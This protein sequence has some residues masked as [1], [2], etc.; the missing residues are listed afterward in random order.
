MNN[1]IEYKIIDTTKDKQIRLKTNRIKMN[2]QMKLIIK[3]Y[4]NIQE[5]GYSTLDPLE[6]ITLFAL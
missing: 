3:R 1:K 4:Y 5:R 2:N 6:P